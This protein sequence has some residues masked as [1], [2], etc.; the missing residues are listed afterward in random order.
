MRG[1][2]ALHLDAAGVDRQTVLE[3]W[4]IEIPMDRTEKGEVGTT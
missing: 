2:N 1:F 4:Q 3:R